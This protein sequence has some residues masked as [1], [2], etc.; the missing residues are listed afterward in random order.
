MPELLAPAGGPDAGYAALEYGADAVYLGMKAF[1]ARAE[2]DNFD[3]AALDEFTAYAHSRP[4]PRHVYVTVNTLIKEREIPAVRKTLAQ[5]AAA[6][7]DAVIVQDLG[8]VKILREEF[9]ELKIH[10]S[11]QMA[12]H[13]VETARFFA[14]LG[15]KRVTLARELTLPEVTA[16]SA[17]PN[18]EVEFFLHGALCYSYSGLCLFSSHLIGRS[19]NRGRCVYPCREFFTLDGDEDRAGHLFSMKD[20]ALY[21]H[22]EDLCR[23]GAASLKIEG[24]KKSPLYVAAVVDFYRR[25]LDACAAGETPDAEFIRRGRER[26]QSIFSRETC[27]FF[28]NNTRRGE[29]IDPDFVGHR[30]TPTGRVEKIIPRDGGHYLCFTTSTAIERHDGLQLDLPGEERPYG[31]AVKDLSAVAGKRWQR[32]FAVAGGC[33]AA[34][35]LPPDAPRITPGTPVYRASSQETKRLYPLGRPRPGEFRN[36]WLL[37][38]EVRFTETELSARARFLAPGETARVSPTVGASRRFMGVEAAAA[39]GGNFPVAKKPENTE[40]TVRG[41]LEKTG[42]Y[43]FALG[44]LALDNPEQRFAPVSILNQLRRDLYENLQAQLTAEMEKAG[45]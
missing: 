14:G 44:E 11:T 38:V 24:R 23:T 37:R 31:F 28:V 22:L 29:V 4:R 35:L 6:R 3:F 45:S 17:I 42:E 41:A 32:T 16:I 10:I 25:L 39:A 13:N 26:M 34:V 9:P 8:V 1:S 30:G 19:A 33:G 27:T 20:L 43:P 5:L 40:P 7:A 2:A 21:P 18:L 12:V 15:V 36:R